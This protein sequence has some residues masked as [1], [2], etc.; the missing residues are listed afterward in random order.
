[1]TRRTKYVSANSGNV[2]QTM[3][4]I[5]AD[6]EQLNSQLAGLPV[7]AFALPLSWVERKSLAD[8]TASEVVNA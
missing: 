5:H 7:D 8:Q 2:A 4:Q 1:M 3:S 6:S